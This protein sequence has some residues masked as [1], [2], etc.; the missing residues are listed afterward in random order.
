MRRP[1]VLQSAV[2]RTEPLPTSPRF[3]SRTLR[4]LSLAVKLCAHLY[5]ACKTIDVLASVTLSAID[6]GRVNWTLE[7]EK[8][9]SRSEARSA[10][11]ASSPKKESVGSCDVAQPQRPFLFTS[12]KIV[13][14]AVS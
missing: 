3:R 10:G 7:V 2:V 5:I 13:A 6:T 9:R 12:Q 1:T 8:L 4:E 14:P 11:G